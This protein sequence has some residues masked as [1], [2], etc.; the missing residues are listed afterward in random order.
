VL[1]NADSPRERFRARARFRRRKAG[2]GSRGG[3]GSGFFSTLLIPLPSLRRL[4]SPLLS[5]LVSQLPEAG[6]TV[7]WRHLRA[8]AVSSI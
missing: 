5:S 8:T 1:K 7:R 4:R 6:A 3:S 2:H